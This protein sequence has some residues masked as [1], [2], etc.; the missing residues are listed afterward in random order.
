MTAN[1]GIAFDIGTTT[2]AAARSDLPSRSVLRTLSSPNPQSKWGADVVSRVEAVRRDPDLLTALHKSIID[3]CNSMIESLGPPYPSAIT[4]AGNTVMEHIF[5]NVS[6]ASFAAAPY[7]PVFMEARRAAASE[8]GLKAAPGAPLYLFPSIG[9]FVGGD[10]VAVILSLG[11]GKAAEAALAIDIGT[12]SEIIL[13]SGG[14]LWATSAAAG[15]AFEGGGIRQG[16]IAGPGAIES[17]SIEGDRVSISVIG[18]VKPKG[19]CGSGLIDAASSLLKSGVM[20]R[21]GRILGR[22]EVRTN[23]SERIREDESGNSFILYRGAGVEIGVSQADVRALQAAKAAIKA[24]ISVLL[25]KAGVDSSM[26]ER[27]YLAGAFGSKLSP[28]SLAGIGG[29]D[30]LWMDRVEFSGDAVL[31]GALKALWDEDG[32]AKAEEI[33]RGAKYVPLSGSAHFER[34]FIRD[35]DF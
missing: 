29:I 15:P 16:M 12:N 24:G 19:I 35:M 20:E 2:V 27:V 10:A 8:V 13:S 33:A 32:K 6:P 25:K 18:G 1:T 21:S 3:E 4:A 11:L 23:L 26:I 22:D 14:T 5:L 30:P 7:R 31:D 34:E 28:S 17:V 9:S